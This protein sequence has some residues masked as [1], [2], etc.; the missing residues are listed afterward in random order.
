MN[1]W[2]NAHQ[3][4]VEGTLI[5]F[6]LAL[7]IQI[8]LRIGLFSVAGAGFYAVGAYSVA[9]L[10]T[11]Y[12]LN[13]VLALVLG[14]AIAAV[15]GLLLAL[16]LTRLTGLALGMATFAFDLVLSVLIVNFAGLTGGGT[17]L[18]GVVS[19]IKVWEIFAVCVLVS[20]AVAL[21]E[22]GRIGR[23][24]E[25][26]RADPGLALSAGIRV[27]NVRIL[28]MVAGAVAGAASGA[29]NTMTRTTISP[30]DIGF[31]LVVLGLTMIVIGGRRSWLGAFVGAVVITWL[32]TWI[33][34]VGQWQLVVYGALVA[35]AAVWVPGG[36]VGIITDQYRRLKTRRH[37]SEAR[38][39]V[40]EI[41][42]DRSPVL[43]NGEKPG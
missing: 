33:S 11:R 22:R 4:L 20:V 37:L 12:G 24:T 43:A 13:S 18:F 2:Y 34:F 14:L 35:L 8:P 23:R 28:A 38:V 10:T 25:A 42:K 6:L 27:R 5:N 40:N 31:P 29:F 39:E 16:L 30:S 1:G 36:I 41:R 17:G 32:P 19:N 9:I 15:G 3:I 26:V 7:S 21:T